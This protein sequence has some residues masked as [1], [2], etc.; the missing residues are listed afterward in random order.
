MHPDARKNGQI[1][2]SGSVRITQGVDNGLYLAPCFQQNL[3]II[4][5]SIT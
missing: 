4:N 1:S 2:L 5:I 3:K